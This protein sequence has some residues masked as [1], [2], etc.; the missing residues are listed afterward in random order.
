MR[1]IQKQSEPADF[2]KWKKADATATFATLEDLLK[3]Q[4]KSALLNEQHHVC[5]YCENEILKNNSHIE[6]FLS[7]HNHPNDQ[8]NYAN[9]MASCEGGARKGKTAAHCGHKKGTQSLPLSPLN[10][11]D[12]AP[13]FIYA[14]DGKIYPNIDSNESAKQTISILGLNANRLINMRKAAIS[15]LLGIPKEN[16][17]QLASLDANNKLP[18][19]SSAMQYQINTATGTA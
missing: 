18:A 4:L 3:Q 19:F 10:T 1:L 11:T 13:N 7:Q 2:S 8:L 12:L 17:I 16:W 6:H 15:T 5:C 14:A 9:L